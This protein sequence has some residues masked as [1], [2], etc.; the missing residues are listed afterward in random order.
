MDRLTQSIDQEFQLVE[1][2]LKAIVVTFESLL[3][4]ILEKGQLEFR[5]SSEPYSSE[6][7][8]VETVIPVVSQDSYQPVEEAGNIDS[9]G[10]KIETI[11]SVEESVPE[12]SGNLASIEEFSVVEETLAPFDKAGEEVEITVVAVEAVEAEAA[13]PLEELEKKIIET[14]SE[15]LV[16][17]ESA[18]VIRKHSDEL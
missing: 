5:N 9:E 15:E 18:E 13:E 14:D 2:E 16:G 10:E 8:A 6:P 11:A 7:L 3:S 12:A 1:D 4:L 17:E